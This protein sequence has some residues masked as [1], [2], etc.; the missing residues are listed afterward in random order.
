MASSGFLNYPFLPRVR[1]AIPLGITTGTL[2][3]VGSVST[4]DGYCDG[5]RYVEQG[6]SY[7]GVVVS[8]NYEIRLESLSVAFDLLRKLVFYQ[9][10]EFDGSQRAYAVDAEVG[11]IVWDKDEV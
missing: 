8:H 9:G 6:R 1:L 5:A 3:I 10:I 2:D 11:I 4:G 7:T